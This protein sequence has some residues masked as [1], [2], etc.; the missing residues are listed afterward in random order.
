MTMPSETTVSRPDDTNIL[1]TDCPWCLGVAGLVLTAAMIL[2][3]F[4]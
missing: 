2:I 3:F 4:W 1:P